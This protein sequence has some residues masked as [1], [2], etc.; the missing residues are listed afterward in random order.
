M[1]WLILFLLWAGGA[2]GDD[3]SDT[4][5]KQLYSDGRQAFEQRDYQRAYDLFRRSFMI[6]SEPALLFNMASSLQKLGRP[7]EAAETLRAYVRTAPDDP[8]RPAIERRILALEEQQ[9]LLDAERLPSRALVVVAVVAAPPP[10]RSRR[11]VVI[12]LSVAGVAVGAI[13]VGL[14]VGL[15][16][17]RAPDFTSSPLGAH[18]G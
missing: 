7:R 15:T 17:G 2:R 9:R 6:S 1:R 4:A 11:G 14:A 12:A 18:P 5:A 3:H 8:D 10:H 16:V 13:V